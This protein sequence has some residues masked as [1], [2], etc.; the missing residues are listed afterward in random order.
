[1]TPAVYF[2]DLG[3]CKM[4]VSG[5]V[6]VFLKGVR[7]WGG[8]FGEEKKVHHFIKVPLIAKQYYVM[9]KMLA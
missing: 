9:V 1:M 3:K 6:D 2:T 4:I 5:E 8:Q 7:A